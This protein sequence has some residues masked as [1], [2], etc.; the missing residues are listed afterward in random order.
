[1]SL[2]DF[3]PHFDN[4]YQEVFLKTIV[5][6]DVANTRFKSTLSYGES[7]ERVAYDISNVIVRDVTRGSASTIDTVT[8]SSELLTINI[9]RE[10]VFHISD[11][12]VKQA[13][14]L[15]PGT[16]I[17]GKVARKVAIDLDAKFF[18]EV[19]NASY[20]F[21]NG[22]LTTLTSTGSPFDLTSTTV[23]QMITRMNAKLSKR[24]NIS[25]DTNMVLVVDAYAA[26]D[27]EEYL[28]SKNIDLAGYVF[29]NGYAGSVK[30][31]EMRISENLT[32]EIVLGMATNPTDTNTI[33]FNGVT[34]TF[35]ATLTGGASEIHIAS[36]VDITRANFVEWL[37]AGGAAAESE[38]TDTG[39][40]AASA[41]DQLL[42]EGAI[43]TNDN[44]ANTATIIL[45]GSG[46][47]IASETFTDGTDTWGVNFLH[48]YYGKKGAID[49]VVQD[50]KEVD[51]RDTSDRRGTNVFTHYLAG[52]KTFADGA[53]QFLDVMIQ[54]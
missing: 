10:A 42:L 4:S 32:G 41:A 49:M 35:V 51:M 21:D 34:V 8:D 33:T 20:D 18:A 5:S 17:G 23:P 3:K 25:T 44:S 12:E 37:N 13:G 30:G 40:S 36:T 22:D 31:A 52:I 53:K 9:E 6:K 38:A 26:S 14:P 7:V 50:L 24:N 45:P 39:Y 29:K 48:A 46:R 11:G 16:V 43:A 19:R 54:A 28:L 47:I 2:T 27:I 1:M 15:N